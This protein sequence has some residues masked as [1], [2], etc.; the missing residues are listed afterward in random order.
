MPGFAAHSCAREGGL[1]HWIG[2]VGYEM[3][4]LADGVS[5]RSCEYLSKKETDA[6]GPQVLDKS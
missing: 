1:C 4:G 3:R 5:V 2:S 6:T